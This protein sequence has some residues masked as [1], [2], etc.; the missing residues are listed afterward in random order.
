MKQ[1]Q[2]NQDT[3]NIVAL[4]SDEVKSILKSQSESI[5]EDKNISNNS[6]FVKK[7]L[8]DIALDFESKQNV[9][10]D[11]LI[12]DTSEKNKDV[13]E[14]N[15]IVSDEQKNEEVI[16]DE[17]KEG[18]NKIDVQAEL[19]QSNNEK[20]IKS[21][22]EENLNKVEDDIQSE[23]LGDDGSIKN[24]ESENQKTAK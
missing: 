20:E 22:N 11:E 17:N 19:D 23:K 8:I 10:E 5:F 21:I 16:P 2:E 24:V 6:N 1:E 18:D 13:Q 7:S 12:N 3:S 4:S 15:D 14:K 9:K